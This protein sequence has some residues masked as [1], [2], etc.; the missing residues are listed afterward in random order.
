MKKFFAI[1][2]AI[3]LLANTL[4]VTAL[5]A[6]PT[7]VISIYG[8]KDDGETLVSLN[9]STSFS[10]GWEAAV[11]FAKDH[12]MMDKN[13]YVR[14]VVDFH[15]D[16]NANAAGEF[17]S[18]GDGFKWST[19]YVPASTSITMNLNGHTINRGLGDRNELDGEVIRVD[20]KADLII[21][22]GTITGG[23]SDNGAGGLHIT[24]GATV[25]LNN[26]TVKGNI[27][28]G[29]D[30]AGIALYG[31]STL[32]MTGGSISDNNNDSFSNNAAGVYLNSSTAA[33]DGVTFS[34][35]Q[36]TYYPCMGTLLYLDQKSTVTMKKC[37]VYG[38]GTKDDA[39][40]TKGSISLIYVTG[41]SQISITDT[42]FTGNG[43]AETPSGAYLNCLIDNYNASSCYIDNCTFT[44][45]SAEYLLT[46]INLDFEVSNSRF[47][48]NAANVFHG[49]ADNAGTFTDCVF[50]NNPASQWT[51]YYSFD[52]VFSNSGVTFIRCDF[53][54]STFND[55]SRA[56]FENSGVGSIFGEG[57]LTVIAAIVAI[58]ALVAAGVSIFMTADLKKKLIPAKDDNT[59]DPEDKE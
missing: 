26:V 16:W 59:A 12:D 52:L 32:I 28:D 57:S 18:G 33:F 53:G 9:S 4:C 30:G 17:G 29:D 55:R 20:G 58:V 31:G 40:G 15:A 2:M 50:N 24:G 44:Q 3:C 23:N 34:N 45:N 6:E 25:A 14:I 54:N 7:P 37:E 35:N 8:L 36:A 38:N 41:K 22:N 42:N 51:D 21:N 49:Y 10:D 56:T 13:D 47:L 43:H 27:A 5:A 46:A 19:I 39:L 48:N 1:L 11:D